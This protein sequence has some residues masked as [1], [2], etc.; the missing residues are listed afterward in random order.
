MA[1]PSAKRA[2]APRAPVSDLDAK[3]NA[4]TITAMWAGASLMVSIVLL[5][6]LGGTGLYFGSDLGGVRGAKLGLILG[7]TVGVVIL[8]LLLHLNS[9]RIRARSENLYKGMWAGM[10]LALV[11]LLVMAFAPQLLGATPP[12]GQNPTG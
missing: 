4:N 12:P 9:D 1:K 11:L 7:L 3:L 8:G 2:D 5:T 10:I 6:A